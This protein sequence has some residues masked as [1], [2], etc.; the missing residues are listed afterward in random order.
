MLFSPGED[1]PNEFDY[2]YLMNKLSGYS[3]PW[4]RIRR[5]L[6]SEEIVRVKKGLYI[7]GPQFKKPCSRLI[8]ANLIFGPSYVSYASALSHYG[9]IPEAPVAVWSVTTGRKKHFKTPIGEFKYFFQNANLYAAGMGRIAIDQER[10]ALLATPEKAL[11]DFV[12]YRLG[13]NLES[14]VPTLDL[15]ITDLRLDESAL[16]KLSVGKLKDL[17]L[18][19]KLALGAELANCIRKLK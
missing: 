18:V 13:S 4:G 2:V 19:S 11:F 17:S 14:L 3:D 10:F 7:P 8:L 9:L 6:N 1:I 5:L 15:L 16:K 12:K